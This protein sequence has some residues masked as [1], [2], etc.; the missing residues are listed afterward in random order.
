MDVGLEL[1]LDQPRTASAKTSLA[2][3]AFE[4]AVPDDATLAAA[5]AIQLARYNGQAQIPLA[6]ARLSAA[7]E[8]TW[9]APIVIATGAEVT[10]RAAIDEAGGLLAKPS[11]LAPRV[12][13]GSAAISWVGGSHS[14]SPADSTIV[15]LIGRSA[16][17]GREADLHL[18]VRDGRAAFLYNGSVFQRASVARFAGHLAALV[19]STQAT[20]AA[21][22]GELP[23]LAA[24]ERAWLDGVAFGP[25]QAL[26]PT[27][28]YVRIAARARTSPDAVAVRHRDAQ[29]TYAELDRRANR[30]AHEL[31]ARGAKTEARVC[32]CIEPAL[33]IAVCMLAIWKAGAVYVPLDPTY[34]AARIAVILEDTRPLV[35]L[36]QQKLVDKIGFAGHSTL[37]LD[38]A[39]LGDRDT[40]PDRTVSPDDT[41]Y[42]YYTSG[43]TGKP[44]GVMA[45][46][47]NLVTYIQVAQDRYGIT[48]A[49]VMPAIARFSF[50][51]S[52]LELMSPLVAGGTL[53]VLDRE[54]VLDPARLVPQL[55]AT[56]MFHAGPSLL[57]TIFAHVAKHG[58]EPAMFDG[59]RHASSGGDLIAPE[60]LRALVATFR[61]AEIFVIYGCS[62]IACMG[63]TYP[64]P[65][66]RPIER[67]YVGKPFVNVAARVLDR[68]GNPCPVGVAGEIWF[69]G[70]GIA[71]GYLD[72]P[73]LTAEKFVA[74]DGHRWYRTGDLG[75]LSPDG[76]VEILGRDDFQIKIRGMRIELAEVEYNLRKAP[77]VKDGVVVARPTPSGERQLV[78]YIVP[79]GT[80][81]G[82]AHVRRHMIEQVPDYMVPATYVELAALPINH[83][84]KVDRKALPDPPKADARAVDVARE[85]E[86]DS[87][88]HLAALW[89]RLLGVSNV[90]LDDNFF[91]LGGDSL[92]AMELIT[93][94]QV[95]RNVVLDGLDILKES[96]E[97]M[98]GI[99]DRRLGRTPPNRARGDAPP[100][101]DAFF[102]GDL[103]ATLRPAGAKGATAALIVPPPGQDR[104]RAHFVLHQVARQLA[105]RGIPAMQLDL[106][107]CADSLGESRDA[108]V[109]RWKR[110]IADATRELARR[111]GASNIVGIGVRLG[112][113]LLAASDVQFARL[114]LWDPVV[115]GETWYGEMRHVHKVYQ[116][117]MQHLRQ[118]RT[119]K[120]MT[121]GEELLGTTYGLP[122]L[123]DLRWMKLAPPEGVPVGWV[124]TTNTPK[125]GATRL[126]EID[127]GWADASRL[128]DLLPDLGISK[129]L[130]EMVS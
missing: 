88:R 7:G 27:P 18:V 37:V 101:L 40:P 92:T 99:V 82:T 16:A 118:G 121:D 13:G 48:A 68:A 103:Y 119:V 35:V 74:R 112:A 50:S 71:K 45:S 84:M 127:C 31:I 43:T 44:K 105:A 108:T 66:D 120:P 97:V 95:D 130:V 102:I 9:T 85:P 36:T 28:L 56:T 86:T 4:L 11:V 25:V 110:D 126:I 89:S 70:G 53:V 17:P 34:P 62:E 51:I 115:D 125:A 55:A 39:T 113:L 24:D 12:E 47:A 76:W 79:D 49:E 106:Y 64:V 15:G 91:E 65:R 30:L 6:A 128:D 38:R 3:H 117:G 123:R 80:M 29:L 98:A 67:T 129:A 72:R 60:V 14:S 94:L 75:R 78:A 111:T 10:A 69:A 19:A 33:D 122:A 104:V 22:I 107:G 58:L 81:P 73:E 61:K 63:C 26:D 1:P 87:E 59:V 23:M 116:R 109:A 83:N 100:E 21:A 32:V 90:R 46:Q 20:P 8:V 52:M 41:A 77:G 5:F 114:A 54:V 124:A 42:I 96:L 2:L 57:K 93:A